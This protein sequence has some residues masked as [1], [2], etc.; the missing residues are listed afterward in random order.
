MGFKLLTPVITVSSEATFRRDTS[1]SLEF[2]GSPSS[3]VPRR[4]GGITDSPAGV[5]LASVGSFFSQIGI[6][7]SHQLA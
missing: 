3:T 1:R 6:C 4:R 5:A 7:R 2:L